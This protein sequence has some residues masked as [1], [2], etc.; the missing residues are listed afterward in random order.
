M[1]YYVKGELVLAEPDTAVIDCGGVG[2]K[3]SVS[4]HTLG[5]ISNADKKSVLL[6]TYMYIREDALDLIGFATQE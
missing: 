5:K 4:D 6:Y 3:L 2:Y 1:F